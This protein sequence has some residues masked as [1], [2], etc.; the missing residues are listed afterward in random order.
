MSS[1][2]LAPPGSHQRPCSSQSAGFWLRFWCPTLRNY[3]TPSLIIMMA[4]CVNRLILRK[5]RKQ[6]R[7]TPEFQ[8]K[9]GPPLGKRRC[10]REKPKC[11][12]A[13]FTISLKHWPH[14]KHCHRAEMTATQSSY[15]IKLSCSSDPLQCLLTEGNRLI[16]QP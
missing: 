11:S 1:I 6:D 16:S 8:K 7:K 13:D 4:L 12:F 3:I 15:V 14:L 2:A 10:Q 5:V 9:D